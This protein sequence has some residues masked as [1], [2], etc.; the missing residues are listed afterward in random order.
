[1]K[2]PGCPPIPYKGVIVLKAIDYLRDV[3]KAI[4][5]E[6]SIDEGGNKRLRISKGGR[7]GRAKIEGLGD[8]GSDRDDPA[9]GNPVSPE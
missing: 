2:I 6:L 1:M 4:E 3:L 7:N 5:V 9:G 8:T